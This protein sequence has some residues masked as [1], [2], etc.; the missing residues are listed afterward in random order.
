MNRYNRLAE[1]VKIKSKKDKV[2][3]VAYDES[4]QFIGEGRSA[5]VFRIK[6][7]DKAIK[8]FFPNHIHIAKEEAEIYKELQGISYYPTLYDAGSNYLVIDYIEGH[9]LFECLAQGIPV[10]TEKIK[11][12]DEAL[13]LA[14]KKGLNPSDIHLRNIFIT[15][16]KE[17]KVI[18]VAR[19]R[20]TK[21]C[22]QWS[23]LKDAFYRVY[24]K[25]FFPKKIPAFI[26]NLIAALYKRKLIPM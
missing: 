18:D 23:D 14:K 21:N 16:A 1:S 26:L 17:I 24:L 2:I 10:T 11:E 5:F 9:T 25:P 15:S 3:L 22:T 6:A 12:V 19:F 20:Q 8:V 7:T 4:L 13:L